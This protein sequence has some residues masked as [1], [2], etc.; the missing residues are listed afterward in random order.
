[1]SQRQL[2]KLI[3]HDDKSWSTFRHI[4]GDAW[5]V[6]IGRDVSKA[7]KVEFQQVG[8]TVR[9]E[10]YLQKKGLFRYKSDKEEFPA[11]ILEPRGETRR[12]VI[13]LDKAGKA[14]LFNPDGSPKPLVLKLLENGSQVVG[15]DLFEQGEFLPDGNPLQQTRQVASPHKNSAAY[16]YG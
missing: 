7:S 8:D 12:T 10:K 4:V 3:P 5:D 6:L 1:D 14:A 11:V 2:A 13:W 9:R 16:T 15:L